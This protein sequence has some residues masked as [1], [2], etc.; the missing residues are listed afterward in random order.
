MARMRPGAAAAPDG[1]HTGGR[2][3]TWATTAPWAPAPTTQQQQ[4]RRRPPCSRADVAASFREERTGRARGRHPPASRGLAVDCRCAGLR[5]RRGVHEG[6]SGPAAAAA[7]AAAASPQQPR[8]HVGSSWARVAVRQADDGR[9]CCAGGSWLCFEAIR[10][11]R[12]A[13]PAQ[14]RATAQRHRQRC[15]LSP[16][17]CCR[18][19]ALLT[20]LHAVLCCAVP[21]AQVVVHNLPWDCTWQ[22]LKDAFTPCGDIERADVVFDSRG[23][24]R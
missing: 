21:A 4:P 1:A 9:Q 10:C 5:P 11:S 19:M 7:A 16:A 14:S 6:S 3:L 20:W 8:E 23:R 22:Q 12:Q 15:R 2:R 13:A 17:C 18:G 24:S